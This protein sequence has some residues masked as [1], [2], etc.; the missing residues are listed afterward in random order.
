M[1]VISNFAKIVDHQTYIITTL[2]ILAT[3]LCN[4][5]G[6]YADL[7]SG[8]I[9]V[10]IIFPIVFSINSAYK[11][12]E[13]TLKYFASLKANAVAIYYAH[14]DWA[15]NNHEHVNRVNKLISTL[16]RTL[17]KYF[18]STPEEESNNFSAV[19]K[20]FSEFS[21][22]H[23]HLRD[24]NVPANEISRL[25]QY[26]RSIIIDFEKMRNIFLYRTPV[27]LRAYSQI[28]LNIFPILYAPYFASLCNKFHGFAG[29]CVAV[30]YSIVLVSLDNIQEDLE[31][32]YDEMG[33]DD[34]K[35]DV[36]DEYMNVIESQHFKKKP[37]SKAS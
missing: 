31:S 20:V 5:F 14:R 21:L 7:P 27:S 13:E 28:F 22:S 23:E 24:A 1:K 3:F 37:L 16:F 9:G 25:N 6:L 15:I 30:T 32:P 36:V 17:K 10:A 2:A 18:L 11:R 33:T 12:R 29:Y 26:L 34:V 19:Y 35:L 4:K 8:L